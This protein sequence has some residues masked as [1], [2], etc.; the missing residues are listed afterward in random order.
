VTKTPITERLDDLNDQWVSFAENPEARILVWQ[1]RGDEEL[2]V[3]TFVARE[4][5]DAAAA[6]PDTF[7]KL[8]APFTNPAAH[9]YV[10]REELIG[11]YEQVREGLKADGLPSEW[12]CPAA[13]G[14]DDDV[15]AFLRALSSLREYH[16]DPETLLCVWLDPDSACSDEAYLLWLQR[17]ARAAPTELRFIVVD[18]PSAGACIPLLKVEGT[19]VVAT[20]CDLDMPSALTELAQ[21]AHEAA[22]SAG[23]EFRLLL[24]KVG[25]ETAQ[26]S[27][28]TALPLAQAAIALATTQGWPQLAA[29]VH[30]MLGSAYSAHG[31]PLAAAQEYTEADR[32]AEESEKRAVEEG[33]SSSDGSAVDPLQFRQLRLNARFG[34]A[35]TMMACGA[36]D[37]AAEI[38][39]AA[40]PLAAAL[41]DPR[42]ELDCLRLASVCFA[43]NAELDKAWHAGMRGLQHAQGMEETA[44]AASTLPYLGDHLLRMTENNSAFESYRAGLSKQFD[45]LLGANWRPSSSRGA[46]A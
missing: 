21:G 24:A 37:Q 22:P 3:E 10:L 11:Y 2:L 31:S 38:Y 45:A 26:G 35:A 17:I 23:T 39:L 5:D 25:A 20:P 42:S 32:L 34:Q 40:A 30:L 28:T 41:N 27:L 6:T 8:I 4:N 29:L 44:R 43:Q 46:A 12:Q 14:G 9:G 36:W 15:A 33:R 13:Q 1:A 19:R 16:A 7:L 18:R